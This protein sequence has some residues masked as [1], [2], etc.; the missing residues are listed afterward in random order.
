MCEC[1]VCSSLLGQSLFDGMFG[2]I[3]DQSYTMQEIA[4]LWADNESE[5]GNE[6]GQ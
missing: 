5:L 3:L 4:H 2:K 6:R 1:R